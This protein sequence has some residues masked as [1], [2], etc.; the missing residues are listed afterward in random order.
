MSLEYVFPDK[1]D[2]YIL[3]PSKKIKSNSC[4][5]H[6]SLFWE[7]VYPFLYDFLLSIILI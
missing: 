2:W 3:L 4:N 6:R 5:P 7:Y 1:Q